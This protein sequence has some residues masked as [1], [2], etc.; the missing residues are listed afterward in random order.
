MGKKKRM[1]KKKTTAADLRSRHSTVRSDAKRRSGQ[2][3]DGLD[4]L[5]R[6]S[7]SEP[8]YDENTDIPPFTKGWIVFEESD[9][10]D[11]NVPMGKLIDMLKYTIS[12]EYG[13]LVEW[14]DQKREDDNLASPIYKVEGKERIPTNPNHVVRAIYK[15]PH[16][17]PGWKPRIWVAPGASIS[18][19]KLK[20]E[21]G[22]KI[23][24]ALESDNK[25]IFDISASEPEPEPDLSHIE[26]LQNPRVTQFKSP[27][28]T[29]SV[30][31]RE[32]IK[33]IPIYNNILPFGSRKK[34]KKSNKKI[35][36]KKRKK[37]N[38]KNKK[39][40]KNKMK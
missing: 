33:K 16:T 27:L 4:A 37:T 19:I 17:I 13:G 32:D 10:S 34:K 9:A 29:K 30:L 12:G 20:I 36:K 23:W 24:C 8:I 22:Y 14:I 6:I 40:N 11:H 25:K 21:Q 38:N 2:S 26:V 1:G 3:S 15:H 39:K 35:N 7:R 31:S 18:L 5:R 28:I